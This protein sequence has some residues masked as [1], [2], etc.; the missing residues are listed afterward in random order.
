MAYA[1]VAGMAALALLC[2]CGGP[3][4]AAPGVA[5][6]VPAGPVNA[7]SFEATGVAV[8]GTVPV[9]ADLM[10]AGGCDGTTPINLS[11]FLGRPMDER[12]F[13]VAFVTEGV[14]APGETGTF[15]LQSLQWDDGV[16][17][18]ENLPEDSP[19][20][21]PVRYSGKGTLTLE[22][23]MASIETRRMAGTLTGHVEQFGKGPAAD[24]TA[25]F[26]INFSCGVR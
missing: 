21:A 15:P 11:I 19:A 6:S 24:I 16:M 14:I 5:E 22:T 13:N 12:W 7:F 26:D 18:P 2:A 17:R 1:A 3:R 10:L 9:A 23:H 4:Q 20:R 25:H 8:R